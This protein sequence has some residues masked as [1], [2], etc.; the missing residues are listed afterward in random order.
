VPAALCSS[1]GTLL[2]WAAG[3]ILSLETGLG[4]E[5]ATRQLDDRF[6]VMS[7]RSMAS[8]DCLGQVVSGP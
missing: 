8:H 4:P 5:V 6:R 1:N 7:K 3:K 2:I